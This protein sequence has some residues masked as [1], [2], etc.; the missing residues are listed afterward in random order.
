MS[1]QHAAET[2]TSIMCVLKE[3]VFFANTGVGGEKPIISATS[4]LIPQ[5]NK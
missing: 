3:N 5:V 4:Y 1:L 2:A